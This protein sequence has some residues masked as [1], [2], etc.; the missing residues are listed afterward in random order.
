MEIGTASAIGG[1]S[2]MEDAFCL[3]NNQDKN[4]Y[5]FGGVFDGHRSAEWAQ[6]ISFF[7]SEMAPILFEFYHQCNIPIDKIFDLIF[8]NISNLCQSD[9]SGTTALCFC[10]MSDK[11]IVANA[12]DSRM[13][14]FT[15]DNTVINI[16]RDHNTNNFDEKRRILSCGGNIQ[17]SYF[18]KNNLMLAVSRSIG[19]H[20]F[21][22]IG[23]IPNPEIFEI[24]TPLEKDGYLV[25]ATDGIWNA[26]SNEKIRKVINNHNSA[27]GIANGL[28]RM[29]LDDC[30][31]GDLDYV[32]NMTVI[33]IKI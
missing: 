32:D 31:E 22:S 21:S 18:V 8:C 10:I 20:Y 23:L 6:D 19:D 9:Y 33:I 28:I 2:R 12:G 25:V 14:L 11:I 26:L 24:T 4:G 30:E 7:A 29:V 16:T 1:R 13:V 5:I 3:I 15:C 27:Q 17:G